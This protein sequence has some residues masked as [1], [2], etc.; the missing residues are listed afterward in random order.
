M[1]DADLAARVASLERRV[2]ELEGEQPAPTGSS[3][4][5]DAADRLWALDELKRRASGAG[6]I[7]Y[8][9]VATLPYGDT[10]DWQ[11]ST[12]VAR[13]LEQDWTGFADVIGPGASHPADPHATDRAGVAQRR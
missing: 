11:N 5:A 4:P 6:Q 2:E 10:Y 12:D 13:L 7:L 8:A 1:A 9:G 3:I